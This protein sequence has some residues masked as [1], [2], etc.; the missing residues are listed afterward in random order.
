[1]LIDVDAVMIRF[2]DCMCVHS[3]GYSIG[4]AALACFVLFGAL[5][6]EFSAFVR[7]CRRLRCEC[8]SFIR[9][10]AALLQAGGVPFRTIDIAVPEVLIGGLLGVM[11]VFFFVGLSVAAV[12]T[13]AAEVVKEVRRQF[14]A[15]PGIM[16]FTA[17]PDYKSCVALVTAA[18]LREMRFPGL[19]AAGL[20]VV[21][22]LFFRLIGDATGRPLLGAEVLVS[23]IMFG[24]LAGIL[25]AL[26]LDNVGGAWVRC[27]HACM[28][29]MCACYCGYVVILCDCMGDRTMRRSSLRWG[30]MVAKAVKLIKQL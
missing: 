29:A 2:V 25:M 15:M 12:G 14:D 11:M 24:T 8:L 27:V 23:F 16:D 28:C 5:L 7:H 30:I 22:G 20:P 18:G 10:T 21:V 13:T 26:F 1:M 19:L 9:M 6:D 17:K 4:S 3:K